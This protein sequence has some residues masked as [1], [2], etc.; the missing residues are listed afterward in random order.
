MVAIEMLLAERKAIAASAAWD[1]SE[2]TIRAKQSL[3]FF[4]YP[5]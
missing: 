2:K 1:N 3:I 4:V 5:D